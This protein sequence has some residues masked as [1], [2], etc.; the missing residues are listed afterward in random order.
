MAG[1]GIRSRE[2]GKT[3]KMDRVKGIRNREQRRETSRRAGRGRG[4]AV[5]GIMSNSQKLST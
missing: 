2:G 5:G 1:D 4:E 3:V